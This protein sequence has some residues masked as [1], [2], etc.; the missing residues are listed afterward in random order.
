MSVESLKKQAKTL[1]ELDK[2]CFASPPSERIKRDWVKLDVV[3]K[4]IADLKKK[5]KVADKLGVIHLKKL[6]ENDKKIEKLEGRLSAIRKLCHTISSEQK[7][8]IKQQTKILGLVGEEEG[9]AEK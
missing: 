6:D 9:A 3:L 8:W 1:M 7:D 2:L 4:Q 5:F